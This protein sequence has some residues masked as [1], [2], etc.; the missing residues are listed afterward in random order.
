MQRYDP[1]WSGGSAYGRVTQFL[2]FDEFLSDSTDPRL[3][4][5]KVQLYK[6]A[7]LDKLCG[8]NTVDITTASDRLILA[9]DLLHRV[10]L[11]PV[12][13]SSQNA[14]YVSLQK[15]IRKTARRLDKLKRPSSRLETA[16]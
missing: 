9:A 2:V 1:L 6:K 14:D 12:L 10:L 15:D 8:L 5:A 11:V 7:G 13:S 3:L 4:V 16:S